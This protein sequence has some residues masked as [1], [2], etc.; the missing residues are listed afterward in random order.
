MTRLSIVRFILPLAFV[1]ALV[2]CE[3][4]P[5]TP[6]EDD[7]T[8]IEYDS[9]EIEVDA[10]GGNYSMGYT[11]LNGIDG[12][13]PVPQVNVS[14]IKNLRADGSYIYFTVEANPLAEAR[15]TKI[16]LK[17]PGVETPVL[18]TVKQ[19]TV[20]EQLFTIEITA[21]GVDYATTLITPQDPEMMYVAFGSSV[22]YMLE[23]GIDS[24][25]A[26]FED[27]YNYFATYSEQTDSD[28]IPFMLVNGFAHKEATSVTWTGMTL[29]EPFVIYAYGIKPSEDMLDYE[30]ATP[31]YHIIYTP[32]S[33]KMPVVEFEMNY[34]INGPE[35]THTI[36]PNGWEGAYYY[37]YFAE[38]S[39]YYYPEELEITDTYIATVM[40][41]WQQFMDV[42]LNFGYSAEEIVEMACYYDTF[43]KSETLRAST[44]YM[45]QAYAIQIINGVPK[46]ASVPQITY[47]TTGDVTQSDMT[48]DIAVENCYVRV[49]DIVVTPSTDDEPYCAYLLPKSYVPEGSDEDVAQ[50]LLSNH[51]AKQTYGKLTEH[52]NT[53]QPET[54]YSIFVVGVLGGVT[55]TDLYRRDFRTESEGECL[56]SVVSIDYGGPYSAAE[57]A[58]I[59]PATY[60]DVAMYDEYGYYLMWAEMRTAEPTEDMFYYHYE[61]SEIAALGTDG[62][63]ADLLAN[64][65]SKSV[66][67]LSGRNDVQFVL[68]GVAMDYRGN[69]SELWMSDPFSFNLA[70]KR[71]SEEFLAKF[72]NRTTSAYK[73]LAAKSE[74]SLVFY[75][76][77]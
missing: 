32:T 10:L 67:V 71:P 73:P 50:W 2:G 6:P 3:E 68:C 43:T 64:Y 63:V 46:V 15:T 56:N 31:I 35:V 77:E 41:D 28:L 14:W 38:G 75:D 29:G 12:I 18:L 47:F 5:V 27:D 54:D 74:S 58:K 66:S 42:Y 48:F 16:D 62:V 21:S 17:Y 36:S 7:S 49:A 69:I 1:V 45:A 34:Q 40:S 52:L 61:L 33:E 11:I 72:N 20:A 51:S 37:E 19:P 4:A 13:N 76:G 60:A 53:L 9:S 57:L 23:S 59:D 39:N 24:P 30:L 8:R 22:N 65:P 25:E 44:K 70:D 26:L 55:T